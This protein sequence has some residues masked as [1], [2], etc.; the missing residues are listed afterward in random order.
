[1]STT[2]INLNLNPNK[3]SLNDKLL[4]SKHSNQNH[5]PK[6]T[7]SQDN[8][9]TNDINNTQPASNHPTI[10]SQ[11]KSFAETTANSLTPNIMNQAIVMNSIDGIKQTQYII[12]LSKITDITNII[13]ASRTSNNRS[14]VFFKNQQITDEL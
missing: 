13:S 7:S 1:M 11:V 14:C 10:S 2:S 9:T 5:S 3:P 12:A 6:T 4:V 8:P